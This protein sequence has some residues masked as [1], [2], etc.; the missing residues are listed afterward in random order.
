M[1]H[2][3]QMET[4]AQGRKPIAGSGLLSLFSGEDQ[5]NIQMKKLDSDYINER[6]P[7]VYRVNGPPSGAEV[8]GVQK[9]RAPL[10]LDMSADRFNPASVQSLQA[11][12]Y[13][14]DLAKRASG[15]DRMVQ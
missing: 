11:N 2:Y 6:Q 5:T 9:Y 3:A 4:V 8:T 7:P 10:V 12:P 14:I 1:R 13:V 15:M